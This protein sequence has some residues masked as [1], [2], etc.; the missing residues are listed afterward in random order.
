MFKELNKSK[1][2]HVHHEE[3][4]KLA[5]PVDVVAAPSKK[6]LASKQK[7]IDE[8]VLMRYADEDNDF[9]RI[10]EMDKFETFKNYK[11]T[12]PLFSLRM[13]LWNWYMYAAPQQM[14]ELLRAEDHPQRTVRD[15]LDPADRDQ[16]AV[17]C[18]RR[19][20]QRRTEHLPR[21]SSIA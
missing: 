6:E 18:T 20:H 7:V 13:K 2:G 5:H 12:Y 10:T 3:E 9:L 16:L 19:P 21:N 14:D 11:D 8:L 4:M 15:V 1:Q 17:P